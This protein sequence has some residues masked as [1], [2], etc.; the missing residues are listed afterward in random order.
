MN[1]RSRLR[2]GMRLNNGMNKGKHIYIFLI[3]F[4]SSLTGCMISE[5]VHFSPSRKFAPVAVISDMDVA[6]SILKQ[7]HPSLYWYTDSLSLR[8]SFQE[9]RQRVKD[10]MTEPAVRNL[11]NEI[12]STVRCGHTSVQHSKLYSRY[13]SWKAPS[14]FPF[15][16]KITDDTTLILTSGFSRTDSL[17]KRGMKIVSVNERNSSQIIDSLFP[18]IPVDGHSKNF[19]YQII[20]N[21]FSRFYNSRFPKDSVYNIIYRDSAGNLLTVTRPFYNR[22]ADTSLSGISLKKV[23]KIVPSNTILKKETV[24]SFWV[25]S[26]RRYAILKLNTF[27]S[28]LKYN[29]IRKQ[30]KLL[31]K[32]NIPALIIDVRNNGGGIIN[33]SLYL[34]RMIHD[35]PF[36]YVDSIETNFKK[37]KRIPS[38]SGRLKKRIWINLAM[39]FLNKKNKQ[40]H[41]SFRLFAGKR[42]KPHRYHFKGRVIFLTG[43][44][45][46]SATSMLLSSLK[47][48]PNVQL[49]G[50]ETGGGAYGNNGVFIPDLIL[51]N[52]KL[53]MRLPLY[54]IINDHTLKNNGRGVMP[55]VEV[56]A[57]EESIRMNK[58]VK[59]IK[60]ESMILERR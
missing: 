42:Y 24:R 37:I 45:S 55:D 20:S 12:L 60:A 2:A 27:S 36:M 56:K 44:S 31:H 59:M 50:E 58:D 52:T 1:I 33:R 6:E 23:K 14:G 4:C 5:S 43:G 21:N 11:L 16:C 10:S 57:T 13:I 47:G 48:L 29:Y 51:P 54:R 49:V 39:F 38:S 32:Q 3:L 25:D 9:G 7:Y 8:K 30:F 28:G 35:Q 22:Y 17:L 19:S 41:Y 40:D 34:A 15:I 26:A 53:R 18:L 46:F